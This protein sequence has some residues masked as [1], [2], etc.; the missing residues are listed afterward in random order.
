MCVNIFSLYFARLP[1]HRPNLI[2][3]ASEIGMVQ[4]FHKRNGKYVFFGSVVIA[5]EAYRICRVRNDKLPINPGFVS[6]A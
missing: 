3:N 5:S 2:K 1:T 4:K 6:K